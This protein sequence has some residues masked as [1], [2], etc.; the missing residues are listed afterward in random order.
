MKTILFTLMTTL[1]A[2][3]GFTQ[4]NEIRLL[5]RADD[6]GSFHAANEACIESYQNG[7]VRSVELMVPY[8]WYPE[9]VKML[10]ENPGLDVGIHLVLTSEWSNVKW[11]PLT[12]CPGL[13]DGNGYFFPMVWK[14][15]NFPPGSSLSEASWTMEEVETELRAQIEQALRHVPQITHLSC[16]MGFTHL[17]PRLQTLYVSLANEY[18]LSTEA[19][20]LEWFTG[21]GKDVRPEERI[22]AFCQNLEKLKPGSYFFL[23]HPGKA[24]GEMK[25]VGHKGYEN[26][27][28]DREWVTRVFTSEKVMETI[29]KKGIKLISYADLIQNQNK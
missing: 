13:V 15:D 19:T 17:D 9:A 10:N 8:A 24:T 22:D 23:D 5:V 1:I 7:I 26:V 12:H 14:N 16:H 3:S 29:R 21:W 2:A 4:D 27:D 20:G 11:R 28:I 18:K 6:I 25:T